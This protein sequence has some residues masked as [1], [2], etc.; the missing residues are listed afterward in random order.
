MEKWVKK[1]RQGRH[2]WLMP[3][4][5]ATQRWKWGGLQFKASPRGVRRRRSRD[6][7]STNSWVWWHMPVSPVTAGSIK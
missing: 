3:V 5:L 2:Q 6:P 7:I 4:I 1:L